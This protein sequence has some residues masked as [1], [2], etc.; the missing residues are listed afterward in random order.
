MECRVEDKHRNKALIIKSC[1]SHA[2]EFGVI[3][4]SKGGGDQ[5]VTISQGF[6]S[7]AQMQFV[8]PIQSFKNQDILHKPGSFFKK[9]G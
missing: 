1:I 9:L 5:C 6:K 4:R 7:C 3:L 2:E 8:W